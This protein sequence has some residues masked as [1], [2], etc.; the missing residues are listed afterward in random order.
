MLDQIDALRSDQVKFLKD[1]KE[2][3]DKTVQALR[4]E[5]AASQARLV[6]QVGDTLKTNT[7]RT[8]A[9][10]Q[11]VDG[12]KKD[13]DEVKKN[14]DDN[15]QTNSN[16]SPAFALIVA[17]AALVL[18]PFLAYRFAA[19]QLAGVKEQIAAEAA[20]RQPGAAHPADAGPAPEPESPLVPP[21][22]GE[23]QQE[24]VLHHEAP[25]LG[26]QEARPHHDAD[27]DQPAAP[28]PEKV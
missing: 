14:L 16:I 5:V 22:A 4:E 8:E 23:P 19:N 2:T 26:E 3:G 28:D 27:G 20:A 12:L 6:T 25:P 9:L 1:A 21:A 11:R 13:L 15:Q 18:G 7:A 10:A 24:A 17:L